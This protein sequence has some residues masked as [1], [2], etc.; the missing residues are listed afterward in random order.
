MQTADGANIVLNKT[1]S[2]IILDED[3]REIENYKIVVGSV[4]T[5]LT[6]VHQEGRDPRHVGS[7][8]YSDSFRKGW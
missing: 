4:L 6:V 2:V 8:Q 5:Q 1:G 3:E 7:A